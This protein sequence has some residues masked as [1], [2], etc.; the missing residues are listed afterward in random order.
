[1]L[2]D[3]VFDQAVLGDAAEAVGR[4]GTADGGDPSGVG[5]AVAV[6]IHFKELVVLTRRG[7]RVLCACKVCVRT[8]M[9][10]V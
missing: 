8:S 2:Q 7:A 5:G 9:R 10:G 4:V 1:M 3:H 6:P